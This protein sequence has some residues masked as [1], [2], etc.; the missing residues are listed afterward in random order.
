MITTPD[1]IRN[2]LQ[3]SYTRDLAELLLD[4][5]AVRSYPV[6]GP[7]AV[8]ALADQEGTAQWIDSWHQASD[9]DTQ[10][11]LV[12]WRRAGLGHQRIPARAT[13]A[14][15]TAIA[16]A[17]GRSDH[18]AD[19]RAKLALLEP[20]SHHGVCTREELCGLAH[21]WL[22]LTPQ[23]LQTLTGA[24][25]WLHA[26]PHSGLSARAVPVEGMHSK[27][28][29]TH[30]TLLKK[31]LNTDNLGL[32]QSDPTIRVLVLDP[33]LRH[34]PDQR[35]LTVPTDS[36]A[37]ACR[38]PRVVLMLENKESFLIL[39]DYPPGSR[40]IAAWGGGHTA[41][42]NATLPHI[43]SATILYFGDLD[44]A[45]FAILNQLRVHHPNVTS[46]LMDTETIE[47]HLHLAVPN[48]SSPQLA[49]LHHLTPTEQQAYQYLHTRQ[50]RIEQE[51]L[52]VDAVVG[53]LFNAYHSLTD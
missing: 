17:A 8:Q 32:K 5:D 44:T 49:T 46:V 48:P 52:H 14:G 6:Q 21:R 4:P 3:R 29:E 27:W 9:F 40:V 20:L 53:A 37:A 35:D 1:H 28:L 31:L 24:A 12:D 22:P 33:Q 45:G 10:W 19:A 34:H 25:L 23:D 30:T 13:A 7:T 42:R 26:N 39:P 15:A 36:L 47:K 50:L 43:Q 2:K 51:R 18:Y 41:A 11:K 38:P 16:H